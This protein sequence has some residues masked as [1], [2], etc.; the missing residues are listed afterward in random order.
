M[1]VGV[2]AWFAILAAT[3]GV[4]Q[5]AP[6]RTPVLVRTVGFASGVILLAFAAF[7]IWIWRA[8]DVIA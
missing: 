5:T 6:R 1:V 2:I 3:S 7:F 4:G 8:I